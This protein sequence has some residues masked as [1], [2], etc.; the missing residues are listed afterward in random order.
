MGSLCFIRAHVFTFNLALLCVCVWDNTI[1][2]QDPGT[3]P[4]QDKFSEPGNKDRLMSSESGRKDG[5]LDSTNSGLRR[6]FMKDFDAVS[7]LNINL[8][9]RGDY[10]VKPQV[11]QYSLDRRSQADIRRTTKHKVLIFYLIIRTWLG[12]YNLLIL[13]Q[14]LQ[15]LE[16]FTI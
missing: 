1:L 11:T 14:L 15:S 8:A 10:V 7:G 3:G 6:S 5:F 12:F 2:V 13:L 4:R 9:C 16:C